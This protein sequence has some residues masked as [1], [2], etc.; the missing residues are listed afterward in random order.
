M[1]A[2]M[3]CIFFALVLCIG[4]KRNKIHLFSSGCSSNTIS[5]PR[6]RF[7]GRIGTVHAADADSRKVTARI[8]NGTTVDIMEVPWQG[9][10]HVIQEQSN[11]TAA[12][13]QQIC[14]CV[15]L[16]YKWAMTAAHCTNGQT[17][18]TL[19]VRFGSTRLFSGGVLNEINRFVQHTQFDPFTMD[20]DFSLLEM[21]NTVLYTAHIMPVLLPSSLD[22][23]ADNTTVF[24]SGWGTTLNVSES[25]VNLRGVSLPLFNRTRCTDIYASLNDITPRMICAGYEEGGKDGRWMWQFFVGRNVLFFVFRYAK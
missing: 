21:V 5:L 8:V 24:V 23:F 16:S 1:L 3:C 10:L 22:Q 15:L 6:P 20:Y 7:N 2:K 12:T 4:N 25:Q 17:A 9:S 19:L 13:M 11:P 18:E 14:G